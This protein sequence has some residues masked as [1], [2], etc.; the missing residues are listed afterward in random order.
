MSFKPMLASEIKDLSALRF[1]LIAS[2]KLDGV[3]AIVL[4]GV[5]YS[6]SL[7]PIPNK[8][9]QSMFKHLDGV[10]GELIVGDPTAKDCY[11]KTVSVVMSDEKPADGLRF[12]MFDHVR[13]FGHSYTYRSGLINHMQVSGYD[14]Y[15]P[16]ESHKVDSL[17]QLGTYEQE[18]LDAGYEGLI[19]RDPESP[20][21]YGRSTEREGYL[22]KLKR[23]TDAEFK[24]VGFEELMHNGNEAQ[25][26]E[27][28]R[29]KRSSHQ[30]GKTPLGTLGALVLEFKDGVH[31]NCGTGFTAEE[32]ARVWAQRPQ[33]LGQSAKIKYFAVGMKDVPRHPVFLGWRDGRDM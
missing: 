22:L 28:G 16:H 15:T 1:P 21:K 13:F 20:Y 32:R 30:A 23:F 33:F 4:D 31:F 29:T 2:P 17:D 9:A 8:Y 26:N 12:Y 27:L 24:V 6:R 10:D 11:R 3:R 19:L 5:V 7:K 14:P 25:T 18:C